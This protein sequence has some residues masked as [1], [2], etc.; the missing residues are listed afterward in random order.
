MHATVAHI[1][2]YIVQEVPFVWKSCYVYL[3]VAR[4]VYLTKLSIRPMFGCCDNIGTGKKK[5]EGFAV[6]MFNNLF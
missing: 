5:G 6:S 3:P 1:R 4:V 2:L